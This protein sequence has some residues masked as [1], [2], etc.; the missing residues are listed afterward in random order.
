MR[1]AKYKSDPIF[2]VQI[3]ISHK[4]KGLHF[5]NAY[6]FDFAQHRSRGV[7][8]GKEED[9]SYN[10]RLGMRFLGGRQDGR[11]GKINIV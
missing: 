7:S 11:H 9:L 2:V 5:R 1:K 3:F 4:N 8:W 10:F 6:G